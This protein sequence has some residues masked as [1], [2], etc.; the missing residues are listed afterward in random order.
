MDEELGIEVEFDILKGDKGDRGEKGEKGDK[1]ERGDKGEQGI[2]GERGEKG[3][4]GEKGDK[5]DKGDTGEQGIGISTI[6]Q[7][8]ISSEDGGINTITCELTNGVKTIFNIKNGS[9]GEKGNDGIDGIGVPQGGTT[10]QVLTKVSNE[11]SD[12]EWTD[13]LNRIDRKSLRQANIPVNIGAE[14][15]WYL[16]FSKTIPDKPINDNYVFNLLI[17]QAFGGNNGTGILYVNIRKENDKVFLPN[18]HCFSWLCRDKLDSNFFKIELVGK[19]FN[20]YIKTV[21][22]YRKYNIRILQEY[23]TDSNLHYNLFEFKQPKAVDVLSEEPNGIVPIDYLE[24]DYLANSSVDISNTD[25]NNQIGKIIIGYGNGCINKPSDAG[26]GYFINIPHSDKTVAN[27]YNKQIWLVRNANDIYQRYQEN[28]NFTDWKSITKSKQKILWRDTDG[29]FMHGSQQ[30][31]LSEKISEQNNGIVLLFQPYGS[32]GAGNWEFQSF[33]IPKIEIDTI[34]EGQGHTFMIWS[35][36]LGLRATKYI[37]IW[38]DKLVGH[39][40]NVNESQTIG[41]LGTVNNKSAVL[42]AVFGV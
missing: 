24:K 1:G 31:Q 34:G 22:S 23:S 15:G 12:F 7:T 25:L 28:G 3:D 30:V 38:D 14:S 5:G 4:I 37:N 33:F 21:G 18:E 2:Q 41:N 10:G 42:T 6:N 26:N 9:K 13:D 17:S 40:N 19:T 36:T 35:D 11:D 32:D 16:A 27:L 8:A 29:S 39:T 20:F